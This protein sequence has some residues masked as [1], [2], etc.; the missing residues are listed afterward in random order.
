MHSHYHRKES[1]SL[2]QYISYHLVGRFS[3][4]LHWEL[5]L[6]MQAICTDAR[7]RRGANSKNKKCLNMYQQLFHASVQIFAHA[8]PTSS[9]AILTII[10]K[11][12]KRRRTEMA[13]MDP[14]CFSFCL[15][16][17]TDKNNLQRATHWYHLVMTIILNKS[18][19]QHRCSLLWD[20]S[21]LNLS[22]KPLSEDE[23]LNSHMGEGN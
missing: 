11:Q 3:A 21:L 6:F 8:R 23:L 16:L 1:S 19:Y 12:Q 13:E 20:L 2:L 5:S 15:Y 9:D 17:Q 7:D 18:K 4:P 10:W 14:F 22:Q